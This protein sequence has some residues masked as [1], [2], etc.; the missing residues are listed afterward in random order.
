MLVVVV[1]GMASAPAIGFWLVARTTS[2]AGLADVVDDDARR[3]DGIAVDERARTT[4]E[5][6]GAYV[7]VVLA[8]TVAG[9]L[10]VAV[11]G[12]EIVPTMSF[13]PIARATIVLDDAV[14]V[15]DDARND[16]GTVAVA[17]A[18]TTSELPGA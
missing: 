1:D 12:T 15:D 18:R 17:K 6:P 3:V 8:R 14:V 2:V 16:D 4:S 13:W 10:I 11:V 5:L 7:A 9:T